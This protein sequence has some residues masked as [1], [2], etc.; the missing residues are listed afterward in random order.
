MKVFYS[1][2]SDLPNSTN[3][4]FIETALE[5]AVKTIRADNSIQVEPVVDR[6]TAGVPGAPDIARTIFEKIEESQVFVCD[7]SIINK[8]ATRPTPN[9]N[10]LVELGFAIRALGWERVVMV[11]NA[12]YGG[13]ELLP[14]DLRVRRSVTYDMPETSM[15]RSLERKKLERLLERGLRAIFAAPEREIESPT[16]RINGLQLRLLGLIDDGKDGFAPEDFYPDE[17]FDVALKKFQLEANELRR[18]DEENYINRIMVSKDSF[19]GRLY[20]DRVL[21]IE[22]LTALGYSALNSNKKKGHRKGGGKND[23]I[24]IGLLEL[25]KEG[26]YILTRNSQS[27]SPPLTDAQVW[28]EK[29]S[30]YLRAH[31]DEYHVKAFGSPPLVRYP[32]VHVNTHFVNYIHSRLVLIDEWIKELRA[33]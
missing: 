25:R 11:L 21:I 15:E 5:R 14:F 12:A 3:R 24:I 23:A 31:L 6:D 9:P 28:A 2:Q 22:G 16:E 1:W 29:V 10:V 33:V 26:D 27:A 17:Q 13:P 32:A 8:G 19:E 18:L 20:I 7:V 30:D 4:G